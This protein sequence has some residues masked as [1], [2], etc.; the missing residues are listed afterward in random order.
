MNTNPV[1]QAKEMG[2]SIWLDSIRRSHIQSGELAKLINE[3]GIGG[4]TSNPTIF[5]KAIT[6]SQDYAAEITSL[7]A[8]GKSV[9]EVYEKL[10]TDDVRLAADAFLPAYQAAHGADGFISL[11]VSP[12]L[13]E[14]TQGT[15]E[16]ARRL[17]K[18]VDRPNLMIKIPATPACIPAIEQCLYE[19]ININVTLLFAVSAYEKVA[20]AY[21]NALERRA[22]EGKVVDGIASVAS[23]FV[24]RI[25]TLADHQLAE[26]IQA[27]AGSPLAARLAALQ[28]KVAIANAKVAYASF[29]NIFSSERF[30]RLA[31]LGARVQRPLW[32]S[33]STKN[34]NY[35]DVMYV[36]T[37]LGPDTVN[38]LPQETIQAFADHGRVERTVDANLD[39]ARAQLREFESLGFSLDAITQ[40][41]LDEGVVKFAQSF[42]NLLKN[43]AEVQHKLSAPTK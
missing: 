25:D 43:L 11:E 30:Q 41:V 37:L 20:N 38:T 29:Q 26:R 15:I 42:E 6:G 36:E 8:Q 27:Q 18:I 3:W 32:A 7:T 12:R 39:E 24:S 1:L 14:D 31:R 19:G 16:E 2:Q 40:A 23:F 10:T 35:R 22:A 34:P 21:L 13:A 5:E 33:T 9:L 28:G 17:F 4:E